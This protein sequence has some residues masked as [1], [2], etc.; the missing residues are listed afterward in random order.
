MLDKLP[1]LTQLLKLLQ[2]VPYLSSKNLYKVADYF[3]SADEKQVELFCQTV[4]TAHK[5]L[6]P[7]PICFSWTEL[8]S[9]C[10][11]CSSAKRN[12]AIVCVVETWQELLVLEKIQ[13]YEGV[14]HVLGG[15]ICPLEGIGPE[16]LTIESLIERVSKG[17]IT[18][19]ILATNQT[20]E[21]Q[22][23]SAYIARRLKNF[24]VTISCLARGLPVGSS[25][26]AMDKVTI[27]KALSER[28]PY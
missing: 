1:T 26:E 20:P 19:L 12:Q 10:L 25:L 4:M 18:E 5:K 22:A 16:D 28:R 11:F 9:S 23:T 3:L 13:G 14:Y 15:V 6:K 7:C 24:S 21:G 27:Y 17:E 8:G 2:Q